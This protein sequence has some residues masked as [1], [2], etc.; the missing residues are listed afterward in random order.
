[1]HQIGPQDINLSTPTSHLHFRASIF[2]SGKP[3]FSYHKIPTW[4]SSNCMIA[5]TFIDL[6]IW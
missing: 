1:M 6:T 5:T 2:M 4:S 3:L